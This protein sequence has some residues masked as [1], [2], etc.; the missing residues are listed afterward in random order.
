MNTHDNDKAETPKVTRSEREAFAECV[1]EIL[2]E[3]QEWNADT[4]DAIAT[5]AFDLGLATVN[6]DGWF[7]VPL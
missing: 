6:K 3:H 5:K 2:A 4:V 1:L 7:V